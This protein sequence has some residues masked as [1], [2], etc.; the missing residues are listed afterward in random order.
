[1]NP[2]ETLLAQLSGAPRLLGARCKGRHALFD[3]AELGEPPARVAARHGQALT[4]CQGCPALNA[5]ETWMESV[6]RSLH[7]PVGVLAGRRFTRG[8]PA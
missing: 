4:L 8:E 2:L 3:S 7:W 6:P 1:M 5:C